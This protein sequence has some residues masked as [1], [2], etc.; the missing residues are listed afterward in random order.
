M[1]KA[2]IIIGAIAAIAACSVDKNLMSNQE[3]AR[4]SSRNDTIFRDSIPAGRYDPLM[5]EWELYRGKQTREI[6]IYCFEDEMAQGLIDYTH[7]KHRNDKVEIK[8]E[9]KR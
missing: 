8:R 1:K 9:T 6:T 5:N 4:W 2:I 7:T 3:L